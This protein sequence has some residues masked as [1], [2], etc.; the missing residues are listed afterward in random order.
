VP[1]ADFRPERLRL[2]AGEDVD[3]KLRPARE[4]GGERLRGRQCAPA[5]RSPIRV[6]R[7]GRVLR[8]RLS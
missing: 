1:H 3:V 7:P 5:V 4:P 8:G 6:S 2:P